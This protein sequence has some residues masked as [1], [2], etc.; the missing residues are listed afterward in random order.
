MYIEPHTIWLTLLHAYVIV[1]SILF[2]T[3]E[4]RITLLSCPLWQLK[5]QPF[6]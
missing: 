6:N 2:E 4:V 3:T 5:G 1:Q